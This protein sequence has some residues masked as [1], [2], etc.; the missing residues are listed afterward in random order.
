M[1]LIVLL[2]SADLLFLALIFGF[3]EHLQI[4]KITDGPMLPVND[5]LF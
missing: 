1:Q 3:M 5:L 2:Y 4:Y